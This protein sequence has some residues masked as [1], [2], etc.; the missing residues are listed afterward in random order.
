MD[1]LARWGFYELFCPFFQFIRLHGWERGGLRRGAWCPLGWGM[2]DLTWLECL[3]GVFGLRG[4][5]GLGRREGDVYFLFTNSV[6][7]GFMMCIHRVCDTVR[8]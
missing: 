8:D 6:P 3:D 2:V 7:E 1:E 4:V 5:G